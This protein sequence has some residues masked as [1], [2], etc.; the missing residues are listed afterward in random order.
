MIFSDFCLITNSSADVFLLMFHLTYG[1]FQF[2]DIPPKK[3]API[4]WKFLPAHG[5]VYGWKSWFRFHVGADQCEAGKSNSPFLGVKILKSNES[6]SLVM[7][8]FQR[9]GKKMR[10]VVWFV[11]FLWG[12]WVLSYI[13]KNTGWVTYE[14]WRYV[15]IFLELW[16]QPVLDGWKWWFPTIS[17]VKVWF[18]IQLKQPF[19]NNGCLG[20]TRC[21]SVF[22]SLKT[23]DL[24]AFLR[25]SVS[26]SF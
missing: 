20:G 13:E 10:G 14:D 15:G 3:H 23:W 7:F 17:Q 26:N 6:G 5:D 19:K 25:C 1:S 11:V 21:L 12:S 24:S 16:S 22:R 18:I 2:W 4:L 8:F 9:F